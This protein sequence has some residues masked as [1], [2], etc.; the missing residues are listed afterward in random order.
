M[1]LKGTSAQTA[2]T[3]VLAT[4]AIGTPPTLGSGFN[5]RGCI[6]GTS[7]ALN[8]SIPSWSTHLCMAN[9]SAMSRYLKQSMYYDKKI[10][11]RLLQG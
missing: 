6:Q 10:A 11:F 1:H 8:C 4:Q 2:W 3:E 7:K 5:V 9:N